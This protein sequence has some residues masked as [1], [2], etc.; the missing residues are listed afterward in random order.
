MRSAMGGWV[1]NS[2]EASPARKGFA[3]IIWLA[4]SR[5]GSGARGNCLVPASSL[6]SAE[7]RA[8]GS[9]VRRGPGGVRL[10]LPGSGRRRAG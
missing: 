9:P 5:R 4:V 7:A 8:S 6:R 3:I 1:E 10:V 2:L